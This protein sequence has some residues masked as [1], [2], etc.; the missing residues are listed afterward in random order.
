[1]ANIFL[2]V[3]SKFLVSEVDDPPSV[4]DEFNSIN[5]KGLSVTL[6]HADSKSPIGFDLTNDIIVSGS[7]IAKVV[8][9]NIEVDCQAV[10]KL[11]PRPQF[12]EI[13]LDPQSKWSLDYL[14][15]LESDGSIGGAYPV[16]GL[17][18]TIREFK[19][20]FG[21]DCQERTSVLPVVTSL[22]QNDL[23]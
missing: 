1:M 10:F 3:N 20:R 22:N 21:V 14:Q 16:S 5:G 7:M 23:G 4:I 19:N 17:E 11:S 9:K 18:I 2:K 6:T 12:N 15:F 13:I 8:G